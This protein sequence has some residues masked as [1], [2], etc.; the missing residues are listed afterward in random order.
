MKVFYVENTT[1]NEIILNEEESAHAIRVLR[2]KENDEIYLIDGK[3]SLCKAVIS[4][5]HQKKCGVRITE[6]LLVYKRNYYKHLVVAPTK[7][8]DRFEW[9]L[10]KATEIGVDEITPIL[11]DRCERRILNVE[12]LEKILTSTMKQCVQPFRPKLNEMVKYKEFIK[13]HPKGFI[14]HLETGEEEQL[15]KV[16]QAGDDALILIGPEGDFS[17]EE[18]KIAKE[19]GYVSVSLG[20]S[21]LRVETAAIA[22]CHTFSIVNN[23]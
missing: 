17:P 6:N 7:N 19:S 15:Q 5:A 20:H 10:E 2:L 22:A 13:Q 8:M 4:D 21:R 9:F 1:S 12:R 18:V 23:D 16:Y 3:G 14:A 11:T